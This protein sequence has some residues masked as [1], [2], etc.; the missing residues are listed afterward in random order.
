MFDCMTTSWRGSQPA[1]ADTCSRMTIHVIYALNHW[2]KPS[3]AHVA[4]PL[5]GTGCGT[6]LLIDRPVDLVL[7][8]RDQ[9]CKHNTCKARACPARCFSKGV[10]RRQYLL[11]AQSC[12]SCP[13]VCLHHCSLN[14]PTWPADNLHL[15]PGHAV[16]LNSPFTFF[17]PKP[18]PKLWAASASQ[19][20]KS[21][22]SSRLNSNPV[23]RV[24]PSG[25]M[26]TSRLSGA[27]CKLKVIGP[28]RVTLHLACA[29]GVM[30]AMRSLGAQA[31]LCIMQL[32]HYHNKTAGGPAGRMLPNTAE[33]QHI[34]A[35]ARCPGPLS[36]TPYCQ[37]ISQP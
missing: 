19:M 1:P 37:A 33:S 5:H 29:G 31:L 22:A 18:I 28:C 24:P 2:V 23:S 15:S 26:A 8:I 17:S 21:T 13:N 32:S 20:A 36:S 30:I 16:W 7:D 10:L 34:A 12:R 9:L 14:G 6:H 25:G 4:L 11:P 3:S 27:Q 35:P